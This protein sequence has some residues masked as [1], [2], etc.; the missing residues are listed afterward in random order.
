LAKIND[1]GAKT[2]HWLV[3]RNHLLQAQ[4]FLPFFW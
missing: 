1:E 2:N 3:I 4:A